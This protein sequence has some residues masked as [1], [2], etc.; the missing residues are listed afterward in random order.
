MRLH[1][2]RS[3]AYRLSTEYATPAT[4]FTRSRRR[5]GAI[6]RVRRCVYTFWGC[7]RP[8]KASWR[9]DQEPIRRNA[10]KVERDSRDF[11]PAEGHGGVNSG[12]AS[13]GHSTEI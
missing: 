1:A 6:S 8:G 9:A 10:E 2:R 7:R 4:A 13:L 3:G 11:V 12:K 5:S